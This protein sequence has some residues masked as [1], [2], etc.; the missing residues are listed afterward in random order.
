MNEFAS[1]TKDEFKLNLKAKANALNKMASLHS[2]T[3]FA[4]AYEAI[5][6]QFTLSSL[7]VCHIT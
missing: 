7:G 5:F 6:A 3:L 1:K 4:R 2:Y